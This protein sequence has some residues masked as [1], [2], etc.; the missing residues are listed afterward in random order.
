MKIPIF[1]RLLFAWNFHE[2][3]NEEIVNFY[4]MMTKLFV[5]L[6]VISVIDCFNFYGEDVNFALAVITSIFYMWHELSFYRTFYLRTSPGSESVQEI[7][8]SLV[9][10]SC[11]NIAKFIYQCIDDFSPW[12][13]FTFISFLMQG[14][15]AYIC[16][17]YTKRL[18]NDSL[19]EQLT[20]ESV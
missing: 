14:C 9:L 11:F 4:R 17:Q 10:G 12:L 16:F 1:G 20:P 2:K 15:N 13:C 6:F 5:V 7:F 18:K 19:T 3:S 8:Y